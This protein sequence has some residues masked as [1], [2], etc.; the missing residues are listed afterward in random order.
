MTAPLVV[1]FWMRAA[2]T[3]VDTVYAA[4]IGDAA[5]AA[6][7]LTV[8]FE[9][10]MIA[11][12]VGLST[13]L[14][15]CLSRAMGAHRG[16]QIRQYLVAS[17][18]LVSVV[19]PA[20][21]LVGGTIALVTPRLELAADVSRSFQIY[22]VTL[23]GG[24]ALTSFWSI[25]PDSVIK[26]H[27]DTRSTMWAGI[28]SNVVNVTLNTIFVFVFH[29]GIFGIAFST[30][31]GRLAGLAYATVR[32]RAHERRRE[33]S[34][35][36]VVTGGDPAP[37]RSILALAVPSSLT[38]ALM[39]GE[40]AVINGV[41]AAGKHATEAIA[42]YSIFHRVV[43]FA[44]NPII[45]GSVA[46]LP[47][48]ARRFGERN[49]AGVRQGLRQVG[50]ATVAYTVLL[51]APTVYPA[52]PWI[53]RRLAESPVTIEYTTFVLRTVPFACL[54]GA[55]F[56]LLRPIF[57][58][59]Q[60]GTPGL[61]M[62]SVRYIVLTPLAAWLGSL[63]AASLGHPGL[64]GLAIGLLVAAAASSLAFSVWLHRALAEKAKEC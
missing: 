22:G 20:F 29:W 18:R 48:S 63:A 23:I 10:L 43:L 37:Y 47:Y 5:V 55:P 54:L 60:R 25:I 58:G 17:R 28:L 16:A 27:Q 56:L 14:T 38:F 36:D 21:V 9:F 12:W 3:L 15:S 24:G 50:I 8:P 41:L 52:A 45:A 11:V 51:V 19:A 31:L 39:A 64:Y 62:A 61:V 33:A 57:E 7:G 46:L 13:G 6:I 42:A 49:L 32:A 35:R 44:L 4:T 34:G 53:A 26:A 30:V 2:F 59:M 1:S 40:T